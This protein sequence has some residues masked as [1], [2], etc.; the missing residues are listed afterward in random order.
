MYFPYLK[1]GWDCIII[2][3][4]ENNT[5]AIQHLGTL[6]PVRNSLLTWPS[7][8]PGKLQ[9]WNIENIL[10]SKELYDPTEYSHAGTM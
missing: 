10:T 9:T 6:V 3:A 8:T 2:S 5:E 1:I 7:Y 4:K